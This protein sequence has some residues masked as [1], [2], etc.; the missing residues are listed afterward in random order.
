MTGNFFLK[1]LLE[2]TV[3]KYSNNSNIVKG[4]NHG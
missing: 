4:S 3:Q 2:F 1:K